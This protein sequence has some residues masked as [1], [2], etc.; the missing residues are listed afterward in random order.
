MKYTFLTIISVLVLI[1]ASCEVPIQNKEITPTSSEN[2]I[3]NITN[4]EKE[5]KE[6]GDVP[7]EQTKKNNN[8]ENKNKEKEQL[9]WSSTDAEVTWPQPFNTLTEETSVNISWKINRPSLSEKP[10]HILLVHEDGRFA[11]TIGF[12]SRADVLHYSWTVELSENN[13]P[14]KYKIQLAT[15]DG[16]STFGQLFQIAAT[17]PTWSSSDAEVTWPQS[18]NSLIEDTDVNISWKVNR[19]ELNTRPLHIILLHENGSF[20][21]TIGFVSEAQVSH[22]LWH[23]KLSGENIPGKYKI[24]IKTDDG[25]VTVGKT[26]DIAS[27][28]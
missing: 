17:T 15:D 14:G 24:Q 23:V 28:N 4:T 10:M 22:T 5:T 7:E 2:I 9:Q 26:F 12:V 20:A 11:Q 3:P 1:G 6:I 16:F 27:A 18:F 25:F 21:Q 13:T 19:P 8:I